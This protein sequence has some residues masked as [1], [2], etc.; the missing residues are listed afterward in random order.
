MPAWFV[1]LVLHAS[2]GFVG[3]GFPLVILV[4]GLPVSMYLWTRCVARGFRR[5][6]GLVTVNHVEESTSRKLM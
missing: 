2:N 1:L 4:A 5:R 6:D 3:I